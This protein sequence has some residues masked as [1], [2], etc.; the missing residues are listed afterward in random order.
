MPDVAVTRHLLVN[1]AP[2][3]AIV[4]IARIRAGV[5][6]AG[7]AMPAIAITHISSVWG[8]EISQ[9]S[10]DCTART[11]VTVMATSYPQLKALIALV[12]AAVPRTRGTI[13]G[14]KVA[15]ILRGTDGPDFS[16]DEADIHMQTQDF[17]I[18]YFE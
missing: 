13:A 8:E 15:S 5:I 10:V 17:I 2:L 7:T 4:P 6:S 18:R 11:Q 12:R 16:N 14:V 9:Q 3:V 1:S